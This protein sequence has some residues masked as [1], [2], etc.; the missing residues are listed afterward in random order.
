MSDV[1]AQVDRRARQ[2]RA[3]ALAETDAAIR[4]WT[5]RPTVM[6]ARRE[7]PFCQAFPGCARCPVPAWTG[8]SCEA[9]PDHVAWVWAFRRG[10]RRAMAESAAR[11]VA[12]MRRLRADIESGALTRPSGRRRHRK[13]AR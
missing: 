6:H 3:K 10:D 8:K 2:W 1:A 5:T 9:W 7:C 4:L 12:D 11:I 13:W